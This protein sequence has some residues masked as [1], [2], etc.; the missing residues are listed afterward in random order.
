MNKCVAKVHYTLIHSDNASNKFIYIL[1]IIRNILLLENQ[2]F[3]PDLLVG[4]LR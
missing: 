4:K 2:V 3:I 1:N